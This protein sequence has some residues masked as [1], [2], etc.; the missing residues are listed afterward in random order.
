MTPTSDTS[1][2]SRKSRQSQKQEQVRHSQ[3]GM[4]VHGL[5]GK[6][7]RNWLRHRLRRWN[8]RKL[9]P[10]EQFEERN[11]SHASKEKQI[12]RE[13]FESTTPGPSEL[14]GPKTSEM[15]EKPQR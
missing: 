11:R 4:T 12:S 15:T 3:T 14:K 5:S 7:G 6:E 8:E 13:A 1:Q 10:G 2:K 9:T